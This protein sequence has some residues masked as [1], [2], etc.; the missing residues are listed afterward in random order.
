VA[1]SPGDQSEIAVAKEASLHRVRLPSRHALKKLHMICPMKKLL[2]AMVMVFLALTPVACGGGDDGGGETTDEALEAK[3]QEILDA[4]EIKVP[5]G[6]PPNKILV[7]DVKVGTGPVAKKGDRLTLYYI[8]T[9]WV[10]KEQFSRRWPPEPPVVYPRLGYGN[11]T[12][13]EEAIEGLEGY[14]PMREGGRREIVVPDY[15]KLPAVIFLIELKKV[16]PGPKQS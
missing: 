6:P 15:S 11:F 12:G 5:D 16:E 14:P 10:T 3:I 13:I 4:P 8:S 9:A 7:K 1:D 2:V